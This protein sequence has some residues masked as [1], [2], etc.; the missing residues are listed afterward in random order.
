M[1]NF[2]TV[3]DTLFVPMLGRIYA[4]LNFPQVLYDEKALEIKSKLP[5]KLKGQDTQTE[6]THLA[7]AVRSLN[8]DLYIKE[9]MYKN[10][11]GIIAQ[12]GCGLETTFYRDSKGCN[13]IWY[14]IDLPEVIDYRKEIIGETEL[15][16][17]IS[18]SAFSEEWIKTIRENHPGKPILV[19]AS[20][21]F[22]Y[23][24]EEEVINLFKMLKKYGNIEV[25][26]DTVNSFGMKQMSKYMK[27]VGHEE[28]KMY[29]YVDSG[30]KLAESLGATLVKEEPFYKYTDKKGFKFSTSATMISSDVFNIVKMEHIKF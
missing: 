28:A 26:F 14:E 27:Q 1:S 2:N 21:L 15:D 8:M 16:R 10:P 12:L 7:S 25:I 11:D 20:G 5:E 17:T 13:N 30:K 9:F 3:E 18:C 22:Y 4:S 19:T 6:Y 29:F 24:T 23:F